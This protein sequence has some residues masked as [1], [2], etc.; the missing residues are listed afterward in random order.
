MKSILIQNPIE[1]VNRLDALGW[2]REG[3]TEVIERMVTAR[4]SC[5]PNHP[6]GSAGWMAWAEGTC[7][8]RDIGC[9]LPGWEKNDDDHIPS[10]YHEE[11][12]I[13]IAACN[14]DDG[15]GLENRQPQNRNKKGAAM[16]R[17]VFINQLKFEDILEG[18][19]NVIQL[20]DQLGG[21]VYWYLCVFCE[22]DVVRAELSCPSVCEGGFF[23]AFRERIILIGE[24]GDDDRGIRVR[25]SGPDGD[26]DFEISV[27]RKEG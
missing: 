22:G 18:A 24:G 1:V 9:S 5:T 10:I 23:T 12:K 25:R 15:T 4:N 26:S 8:L 17:A 19:A 21:V 2:K 16:D 13:K 27:T 11:R 20:S 7:R 3:L 6:L 14:T